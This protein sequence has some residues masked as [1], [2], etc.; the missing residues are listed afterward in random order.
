M[1]A[2]NEDANSINT[3][4]QKTFKQNTEA[5]RGIIL[6]CISVMFVLCQSVKIVPDLYEVLFCRIGSSGLN[7]KGLCISHSVIDYI[8]DVSH[9][10]LAINSST[11][12]IIYML[13]GL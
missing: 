8:V 10:L 2:L 9:L 11:N 12:V 1:V 5:K 3:E 13:K 6:V 4:P 7:S